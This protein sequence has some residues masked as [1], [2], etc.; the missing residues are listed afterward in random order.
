MRERGQFSPLACEF[1]FACRLF[2]RLK[3]GLFKC[4][5][6]RTFGRPWMVRS[7][8]L[9]GVPNV[10]CA[11][12]LCLYLCA[13]FLDGSVWRLVSDSSTCLSPWYSPMRCVY[14][15]DIHVTQTWFRSSGSVGWRRCL[16]LMSCR[17]SQ[18]SRTVN[19][20]D[21]CGKMMGWKPTCMLG[22]VCSVVNRAWRKV[23][24]TFLV[25]C[26]L[27]VLSSGSTGVSTS[28]YDAKK[29]A[30]CWGF[31]WAWLCFSWGSGRTPS[32]SYAMLEADPVV[33]ECQ[34]VQCQAWK[35][36]DFGFDL[37]GLLFENPLQLWSLAVKFLSTSLMSRLPMIWKIAGLFVIFLVMN[38]VVFCFI[39]VT[40][41]LVKIWKV[42]KWICELPLVAL[43]ISS[44]KFLFNLC[45]SIPK[46][47]E[48]QREDR[49][50]KEKNNKCST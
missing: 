27:T 15:Y 40:N 25:F 24:M 14:I 3:R 2:G 28:Q 45:L 7:D 21:R 6:R 10:L 8:E 42:F 26:A 31:S 39:R 4:S 19:V 20:C 29:D 34:T 1:M 9:G 38:S 18:Y 17:R 50:K 43:V 11:I 36:L 47:E 5:G 37:M 22:S 32:P 35:L 41:I 13:G 12:L 48:E 46:K 23:W 16:K 30:N 44:I 33:V 49:K